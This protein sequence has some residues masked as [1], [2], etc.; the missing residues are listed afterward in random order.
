M[1]NKEF[2]IKISADNLVFKNNE[3]IFSKIFEMLNSV[4]RA[5]KTTIMKQLYFPLSQRLLQI[6][7]RITCNK[8]PITE[9]AQHIK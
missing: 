2:K 1:K 8:T 6:F 4:I 9:T 5:D 7:Q 3:I